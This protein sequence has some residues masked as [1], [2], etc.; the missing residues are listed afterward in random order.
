MFSY[1]FDVLMLKIIFFKIKKLYFHVFLSKKY[2]EPLSLPQSQTLWLVLF[3]LSNL[4]TKKKQ[5]K[6]LKYNYNIKN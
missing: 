1:R 3:P 4:W 5:N 2:F 6:F